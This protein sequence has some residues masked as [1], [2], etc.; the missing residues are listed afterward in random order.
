MFTDLFREQAQSLMQHFQDTLKQ[1]RTG[2]AQ[3]SLIEDLPVKVEAYGGAVMRLRELASIAAPDAALL[4]I[5]IYDTS[6]VKDI[7]KAIMN[8]SLNLSPATKGNTI[9]LPIVPLTQERREELAK[10]VAQ[11]VEEAK[12]A[13]R[14]LRKDIKDEIEKQKGEAGVSED[15]I[16]RQIDELQKAVDATMEHL[17]KLGE[18]KQDELRQL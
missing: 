8:S 17:E 16:E 2:R 5:D 1:I 9:H 15:D 12:V 4:V 6:V 7:E 10:Q 18:Q 11:K 3:P 13:V 14:N